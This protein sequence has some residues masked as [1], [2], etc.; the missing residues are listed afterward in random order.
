MISEDAIGELDGG[1]KSLSAPVIV[2][3]QGLGGNGRAYPGSDL[4]EVLQLS[5]GGAVGTVVEEREGEEDTDRGDDDVLHGGG[6]PV[7]AE[8]QL[9]GEAGD[10]GGEGGWLG[11][12]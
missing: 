7:H 2:T 6:R 12:D 11:I 10:W 3:E 1:V 8:H 5:L 4:Q 9:G